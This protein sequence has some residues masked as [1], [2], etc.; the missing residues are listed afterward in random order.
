[1]E[2]LPTPSSFKGREINLC[3]LMEVIQ[4]LF[5]VLCLYRLLQNIE[6]SSMWY[7]VGPCYLPIL[8]MCC[9]NSLSHVRLFAIPWTVVHQVLLSMR[10]LQARILVWV[11]MPS[12]RG[13]SQTGI[14][15]RSPT[16]QADSLPVELPGKPIQKH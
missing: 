4:I 7:I 3:P 12:S 11:A 14:E 10:I 5:W 6:Y 16:L 15:P 2:A 1:M 13:S 9:A 8:Y